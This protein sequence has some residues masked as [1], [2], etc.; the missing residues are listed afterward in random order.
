MLYLYG[1]KSDF[2]EMLLIPN[3]KFFQTYLLNGRVVGLED[4]IHDL[5]MQKPKETA[6]FIVDSF[7]KE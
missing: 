5:E 4:G 7:G 3:I 2:M 1:K 6:N